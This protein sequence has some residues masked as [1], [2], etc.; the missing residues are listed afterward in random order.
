MVGGGCTKG[1][2]TRR[3]FSR[4][5]KLSTTLHKPTAHIYGWEGMRHSR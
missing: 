2:R 1:T 3:V 5:P 4:N